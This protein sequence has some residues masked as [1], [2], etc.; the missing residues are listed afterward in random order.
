MEVDNESAVEIGRN[1][2]TSSQEGL[3][4]E[5]RMYGETRSSAAMALTEIIDIITNDTMFLGES[6]R[7][8]LLNDVVMDTYYTHLKLLQ[9]SSAWTNT[10]KSDP[11]VETIVRFSDSLRARYQYM[12]QFKARHD[13]RMRETRESVRA[14]H[15]KSRN[16]CCLS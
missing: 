5:S 16:T 10:E 15:E 13:R 9:N 6:E 14:R 3:Q 8:F 1:S 12:R 2:I 7:K 11:L 4:V